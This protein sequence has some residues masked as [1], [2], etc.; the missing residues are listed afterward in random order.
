[1]MH[2]QHRNIID[3]EQIINDAKYAR[4]EFIRK[5]FRLFIYGSSLVGLFWV[6]ALALLSVS[7]PHRQEKNPE[8]TIKMDSFAGIPTRSR[9]T[10]PNSADR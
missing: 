4:M 1:M 6:S 5:N 10:T 2:S 9:T 7:S 8:A 3:R